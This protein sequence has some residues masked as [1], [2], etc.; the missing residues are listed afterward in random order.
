MP[1]LLGQRPGP[2]SHGYHETGPRDQPSDHPDWRIG[3]RY[4]F[5]TL[6]SGAEQSDS[7]RCG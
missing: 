6:D 7:F 1:G 4:G 5:Q 2:L 3:Q